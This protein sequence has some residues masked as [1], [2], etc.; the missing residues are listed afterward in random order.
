M[1]TARKKRTGTVAKGAVARGGG[2]GGAPLRR[3][4][5]GIARFAVNRKTGVRRYIGM[6]DKAGNMMTGK[7]TGVG[8]HGGT[9]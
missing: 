1:A 3:A 4:K 9:G 6:R 8:S 7:G 2:E 5:G